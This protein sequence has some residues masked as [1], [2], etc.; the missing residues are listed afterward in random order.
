MLHRLYGSVHPYDRKNATNKL[1]VSPLT[2]PPKYVVLPMNMH[3]GPLCSPIV[4]VGQRVQLGQKIAEPDGFG[5]PI[6]AS[7]SG[8]ISAIEPRL[9]FDGTSVLSVVIKNDRLSD[10][11]PPLERKVEPENLTGWEVIDLV[12]RAGIVGL[13]SGMSIGTKLREAIGHVDTLIINGTECEPYL[14]ADHRLM[15]DKGRRVAGGTKI[16]MQ[17]LCAKQAIIAVQTN[18]IDAINRL[19]SRLSDETGIQ[20][21]GLKV[22]YPLGAAKILIQKLTGRQIP[23]NGRPVDVKC[24]LFSAATAAAVY[25]AVQKGRP[26]TERIVTVSGGALQE[27]RNLFVPI[28]TPLEHLLDECGG[29]RSQ[30]DRILLGGPM[31][32][33]A[34]PQLSGVTTKSTNALLFLTRKECAPLPREDAFCIRCGR[35]VKTCPMNLMPLYFEQYRRKGRQAELVDLH[36]MDCIECGSCSYVCPAHIPLL[37][38]IRSVKAELLHK[39][40]PAPGKN[41]SEKEDA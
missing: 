12:T 26:L 1:A 13:S 17:T 15:L 28:G 5:A 24:A 40:K 41:S 20:V 18:K 39:T 11:A 34:L 9:Q 8:M 4:E 31:R 27:P 35:C 30:P 38:S 29:L 2:T 21:A 23:T 16:L 22:R 14:T 32:G 6:H 10:F 7:V 3:T 37:Q 25:D 36:I 19:R 33:V